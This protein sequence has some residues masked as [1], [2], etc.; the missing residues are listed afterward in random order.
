MSKAFDKIAAGLQDAVAIAQ[1]KADPESY[2]VHVPADIDV[3]AIRARTGLTQKAFAGR[4]GFSLATLRDW[5]QR[6][7][8]P[9]QTSRAYLTVID[10]D[11]ASV[12]RALRPTKKPRTRSARMPARMAR[13]GKSGRI[14]GGPSGPKPRTRNSRTSVAKKS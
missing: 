14:A 13:S 3:S 4:F 5:E 2:V 1:G 6:R 7:S 8:N 10:R 12:E 9:D 11:P